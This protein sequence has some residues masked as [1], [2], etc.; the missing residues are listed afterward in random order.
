MPRIVFPDIL[1]GQ[2][3]F[4]VVLADIPSSLGLIPKAGFSSLL[5][6]GADLFPD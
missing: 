1:V 3:L 2:P 5:G 6:Y 4:S